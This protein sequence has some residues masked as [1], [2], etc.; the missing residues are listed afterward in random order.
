M[1]AIGAIS[2]ETVAAPVADPARMDV[3][4]F[5][6]FCGAG[7]PPG[8]PVP[9]E[10]P[11]ELAVLAGPGTRPDGEAVLTGAALPASVALAP[12]DG[13]LTVVVDGVAREVALPAGPATTPEA[14]AAALADPA[15]P[16]AA[17]LVNRFGARHLRITR[18]ERARAGALTVRANASLGFPVARRAASA[19]V[20]ATLPRAVDAFFRSGGRRAW[21]VSAGEPGPY[22]APR[23]ERLRRLLRLLGE[24]DLPAPDTL[25]E[26]S[27]SGFWLPALAGRREP[28]EGWRGP[29]ALLGIEEAFFLCLPDLAELLSPPAAPP[30]PASDPA[31]GPAEIFAECV[32]APPEPFAG[33]AARLPPPALDRAG[34]VLWRRVVGHLLTWL[35]GEAPDR[36]LLLSLPPPLLPGAAGIGTLLADLPEA[37]LCQVAQPWLATPDGADLPGGLVPPEAVLAGML[38]AHALTRGCFRSAGGTPVPAAARLAPAMDDPEGRTARFESGPAGIVLAADHTPSPDPAMRH[39]AVRR[40]IALLLRTSARIG[41]DAVFEPSGERLW[42]DVEIGLGLLLERVFAAGGLRGRDAREAFFVR[43]GRGSTMTEADIAAGRVIAE[44]GVAPALPVE[45]VRVRLALGAA[46][47]GGGG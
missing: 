8:R 35:R 9:V 37:E 34:A 18:R 6:G 26:V 43:C 27:A 12:G 29:A 40:L 2:F 15:A 30:P 41:L 39:A 47:A 31:A 5:V 21:I 13:T 20:G 24:Q 23:G 17:E 25:D 28:P 42:R 10:S 16:F 38:A 1:A 4:L 22:L 3:A 11:E 45:R 7:L 36:M 32:T 46:A 14:I 19:A 44:I 33:T